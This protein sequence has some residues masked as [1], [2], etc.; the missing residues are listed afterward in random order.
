VIYQGI[1]IGYAERSSFVFVRS[2]VIFLNQSEFFMT[3]FKL[4]AITMAIASLAAC[5][6][7]GSGMSQKAGM[8]QSAGQKAPMAAAAAPAAIV[9]GL[10]TTTVEAAAGADYPPARVG[11]CYARVVTPATYATTTEQLLVRAASTT[12][13]VV[14]AV[15]GAGE[16]RVLAKGETRTLEVIP[17]TYENVTER[18]LV[19]GETRRLEVIPATYEDVTERVLVKPVGNQLVTTPATYKTMTERR[20]VRAASTAWKRSSEL[21]AAERAL[22]NIDPNAGD[23]LC[24]IEVPA[25]YETVST[26]VIDQPASTRS[27]EIPAEYATVTKTVQKT[28]PTTREVLIPAEYTTAT[29][30]VQKTP[31]TTREVVIP[32]EYRNVPTSKLVSPAREVRTDV[33]AEYT[34]KSNTVMTSAAKSEWRQILCETNATPAKLSEIQSALTKKGYATGRTDGAIDAGTL[35]AVRGFQKANNLPIDGDRY[36]NVATV[37]ALGVAE[38]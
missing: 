1:C 18:V 31:P 10:R 17:A 19:K 12:I 26:Q 33:P 22:Q 36:I 2:C 23:V 7:M 15:Y 27:I 24:L 28:P 13:A 8:G 5:Q 35:A 14:P 3:L 11:E 38:K 21:T 9:S 20:L 6:S 4:S 32:A 34:T 29:R 16:E 37:R 25:V 30:T